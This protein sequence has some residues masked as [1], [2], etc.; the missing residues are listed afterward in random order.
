MKKKLDIVPG[1]R[2]RGWGMIN[3]FGEFEFVP[4]EKGAHEGQIKAVKQGDNWKICES[5][6][7]V[8]INLKVNKEGN[9]LDRIKLFMNKVNDIIGILKDYDF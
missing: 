5:K 1:Q 8:I 4:E 3:D 9:A 2:Y 6:N 7:F